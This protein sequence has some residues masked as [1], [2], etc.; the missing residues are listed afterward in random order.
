MKVHFHKYLSSTIDEL[1]I[2]CDG[3]ALC[4]AVLEQSTYSLLQEDGGWWIQS[5]VFII[6]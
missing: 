2:H 6:I 4:Q 1:D 5:Q 3:C